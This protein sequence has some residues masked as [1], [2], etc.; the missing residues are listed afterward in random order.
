MG[1]ASAL[2]VAMAAST[3]TFFAVTSRGET[4]HEA[5]LN[6]G[7]VWVSS[8]RNASFARLNKAVSQ[9][10]AGVKAN[11]TADAPLD[12][13]QDGNAV[14][15]LSM[16]EGQVIPIDTRTGRLDQSSAVAYPQRSAA[17][18]LETF[19]PQTVDLR[20]GTVAAVDPKTGKVWA[21]RVDSR[22]GI[23]GLEGLSAGAKP[24][25]TVGAV[26]AV[27]VD[28]RGG[29]HAVSGATGKVVSLAPTATGFAAPVSEKIDLSTK[30]VDITAVGD[31]W[32]VYDPAGD[33]VFAQGTSKP[34]EAGV[35][36]EEGSLAYA[37]LQQPGPA[38]KDVALQG[39]QGVTLVGLDGGGP[40]QGGVEITDDGAEQERPMVSRPL[41][42]GPCLHAA[43]AAP[44][45]AY[46]NVNCGREQPAPAVT[47]EREGTSTLREGVSLRTNR[48]LVVLNDLDG[49]EVWDLDSKPVKIDD[50]ESLIP[51]PQREDQQKKKDKNLID[52]AAAAQPPKAEPDRL[53]ARPGRTSKLHVLDNDTDAAGSILSISPADVSQPDVGGVTASVAAD[54]QSIDVAI[55]RELEKQSFSFTYKVGNGTSP[56][57][58]QARVEV[59]LASESEN[60]PPH[61]RAGPAKLA[62]TAYPVNQGKLLPVQVVGDWRDRESD[63]VTVEATAEGS[64]VDGLGRLS[65]RAPQK[66]GP[67]TVEYAVS[68][69]R[70]SSPGRVNLQVLD[71]DDTFR[72]PQ[73]QPDVVRG[74]VGK[75]LQ[76]EPLG[77][78]VAGA[79]PGEP[80]ARMR[81]S[82]PV[83]PQ[84]SLAVDTNL[85]TGVVT[86]TGS[87]PG[88]FQ[89]TYGAQVGAGVAAGRVRVDLEA[90]ADPDAPPVAVPDSATVRDQTPV[91]TDVLANDYSPRADVLVTRSVRVDTDSSWLRPSIYKGRWVRIEALEPAT[92]G[93]RPRTGTVSYTVSDGTKATTGQIA[94]QQRPALEGALPI[95][96]DDSAVVRAQD[97]VT[98][99]VMDN[100]SMA[101]GV[102]LVLDPGSVK[103][104]GGPDAAFASGNV[105]RYV[106]Q[107]RN[108]RVETVR[109]VEYA[110]Y[111]IG[112][113]DRAQTGRVRVTVK[114]LPTSTTPNQPPTARSF[115]AS[116][117]AG[118]PL[119]VTVPVSGVDTDGDS[120]TVQ[121][122][123]GEDGDTVDLSLGRV[124]SF[125]ASTIRYEAYPRAA[126]T[127]VLHYKVADRFGATSTGFVRIGVVQPGDPQP[128]VAVEDEV[129]AAPGKT[130]T[131]D[132]TEN[133]LIARGDVVDLE[134]EELNEKAELA[135][136]K[137][138]RANTYV[139][140]KVQD[141]GQGVQHLTYGITNGLFDP[142]RASVTVVPTPGHKNPP[143]AVD[144]VAKPKPDEETTL[145]D[146]TANDRD[147][148]GDRSQLKVT[149][150]LSPEGTIEGN[151]VRVKV[152]DHPHTVPYVITD[153]DG[154]QAMALIYVPTGS[155]GSPFVVSGALIEMDKDSTKGVRLADYVK[156]PR[157][158]VVGITSG[159]TISASPR[160]HLTAEADGKDGLTL[161]SSGGYVG[162]AA[163]ML[164]VSDQETLDQKDFRTAYVSIP[165]QVGPKVP[166]LRCPDYA[167][168]VNAAGRPR[169]IDIPTLCHAW[170]PPGMTLDDVAFDATW[171]PEPDGVELRQS[172]AGQRTVS[173]K[174]GRDAATSD[175]GRIRVQARGAEEVSH[176]RVKVVGL[177][178][179][180]AAA[181][182]NSDDDESVAPPRMRPFTVT[183]LK[184][185][186]SQTVNLR[187]YLDSPLEKPG[188][189]IESA[190]VTSGKGLSVSRSGCDL[191]V[192]ASS[193]ASGRGTVDVAVSDGPG[194]A[195]PGRGTVE[196]LG[197]PGAPTSVGA[198]AD[199]VNGGTARVRW[200][201]P[202]YDG[203]SP[204]TSYTVKWRGAAS[205]QQ[206][207][208]ASP[209]TIAGLQDGQNYWFRVSTTNAVGE[210][211]DSAEA[212]PV[213][214]DTLPN[215][216][217]GV[218]MT[219][220]GDGRLDIAWDKPPAK[221]SE[222]KS[223]RVRVTDTT[224]GRVRE[225]DVAAPDLTATVSGLE[226]NNEQSVQVRASNSLGAG[227]FGP[228]VTMQSAGTPPAV[229]SPTLSPRGPGAAASSE[230]LKISWGSVS[231]NGPALTRYT[232]YRRVDGGP[233]TKRADT[234]ADTR[235]YT[236]TIPYDGRTYG[237]VVT[238]TNGAG[239]ESAKGN[240]AS[241]RSVAPPV[242][243]DA[244]SVSTPSAN[245]AA[246][247]RVGLK[248]SRGSG[249]VRL[250][251]QTNDG[252][253]GFV[254]CGCA[255]NAT[256]SFT[257]GSLGTNQQRLRV[258]A[259]NGVSWSPWSAYSNTY[260]PY[261]DTRTPTNLRGSRSGDNITWNWNLPTNGRPINQVQIDG[262]ANGT[263]GGNKT[264]HTINNQAPGTHRLRVRAQS[265]A[266]WSG[267]TNFDSVSIP[268]PDPQVYNLRKSAG[269][270][271][272]PSGGGSCSSSPGC[273]KVVFDVRD[274][275]ANSTWQ[276]NCRSDAHGWR[277]SSSPLVVNGSGNGYSWSGSCLYGNNVGNVTV[278]LDRGGQSV[279]A[280][281]FWS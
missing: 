189:T 277:A 30:A 144:D 59:T 70:D 268:P 68:D 226:N 237:Y 146:V 266:G 141:P 248:D 65:V 156:S 201:P 10:D 230:A 58:S 249:Y 115:S 82:R 2:V 212:G 270:Y 275:P 213:Q 170:V 218:R 109:V 105:I 220:R 231:P 28:V 190:S 157:A 89:L 100:D 273:K 196:M 177:E 281:M 225:V 83:P 34:V 73:T 20:G 191:T 181:S 173:V 111:P 72:P 122:I 77:N 86:I 257:A 119:T 98:I 271:V 41:R 166:L 91:L 78:D 15:G 37:A 138:D 172:G 162:P 47:I 263:F 193:D 252:R 51:P 165:V 127:E 124:T 69:G 38:T 192:K 66:S 242:Q 8:A 42:L 261:G 32:V 204:I 274:F 142:S 163:V 80:D 49:G 176:I 154:Q 280:S 54:G 186:S 262:A 29:V 5:D 1:I 243:P 216:V 221:G 123:T 56:E 239:N 153:E 152:L 279:S 169:D 276:V 104:L 247:V 227:P 139:S 188:C 97:S 260:Q 197:K 182:T 238:A 184:A 6:D 244:P 180:A 90:A 129:R 85:D 250:E 125:G 258:R 7:G 74:V 94:V 133:D 256:K 55:P 101:E 88:T 99:P 16:S 128:P 118:E 87:S 116:V 110:V 251:W 179:Q 211:P 132:V 84:G 175:N 21:Q 203:G 112:M 205:D 143:V 245:H 217:T 130:V 39:R 117:V 167:V 9:F 207:C 208:T 93:A 103:V 159:E 241:F 174:A 222:V 209:C 272:D 67:Q 33:R 44:T 206:T 75:P 48:R 155:D 187:G 40:S 92:S 229:G 200:T 131:V 228:G 27:A 164:E 95:V 255:E 236:D 102:P 199:R 113:R 62:N 11:T 26:A 12:I 148:D 4:V 223:Y 137:V 254:S 219:G 195:A 158:R 134:Y 45:R 140:T 149:R 246:S 215:P 24:V 52:D 76:I 232:V 185:G 61:L 202:A 235:T 135:R 22:A 3:L 25:A 160:E 150:L 35:S 214:P 57:K 194:R 120:V 19:V 36:R 18:N 46:Y 81:L 106:P 50:W 234:A 79:D 264:S 267:W 13:V 151:Q 121:G 114:P 14:A 53:K 126:G 198:V 145:V 240:P 278:R 136:W 224:S 107:E 96:E 64:S 253:S 168:T 147:V 265:A 17:T 178:S 171:D 269:R 60:T 23:E 71:D 233:W 108:P 63:T 183:G 31:R 161:T 210:S 43:W 259:Y